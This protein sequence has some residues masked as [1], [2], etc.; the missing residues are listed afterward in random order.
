[1]PKWVKKWTKRWPYK[2]RSIPVETPVYDTSNFVPM[3]PRKR[4]RPKKWFYD[5]VAEWREERIKN[6]EWE[7]PK[8]RNIIDKIWDEIWY[9]DLDDLD[10]LVNVQQEH[11]DTTIKW[12]K[13][14]I[15]EWNWDIDI[16]MEVDSMDFTWFQLFN[17]TWHT[18]IVRD[19]PS[20]ESIARAR[21][22]ETTVM[23][24]YIQW[25]PVY[26]T[27]DV[28]KIIPKRKEGRLY[29]VSSKVAQASP[30]RD[31]L[32]I[33]YE[34][35]VWRWNC[36]GLMRNPFYICTKPQDDC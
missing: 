18:I 28:K 32:L 21:I 17:I 5:Y 10:C 9:V 30:D 36:L 29:I 22:A 35:V 27:I 4:W 14:I 24:W 2:K 20:L 15:M 31:D 19:G 16:E 13:E 1:M 23:E 26:K 33:P 8:I 6:W 3:A 7:D 34:Y 11:N 25:V 12:T